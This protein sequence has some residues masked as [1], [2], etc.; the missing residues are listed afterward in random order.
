MLILALIAT[1]CVSISAFASF[2]VIS[3]DITSSG[4]E[5]KISGINSGIKKYKSIIKKTKT[6]HDKIVPLGKDKL[7]TIEV[8]F[9]KPLL[10][11]YIS[12]D[13]FISENIVLRKYYE[14]KEENFRGMHYVNTVD[15][16]SKMCE[17]NVKEQ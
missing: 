12:H 13:E 8:L 7:N 16:N 11:S 3:I 15:I 10:D 5:I 6:K 2:F 14:T 4:V 9:S 17:R 1:G